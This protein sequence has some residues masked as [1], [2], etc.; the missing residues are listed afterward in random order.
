MN[1][2]LADYHWLTSD[3]AVSC[4]EFAASENN[5]SRVVQSLRKSLTAQRAHLVIEQ[6]ELRRRAKEKFASADQMFFTRQSLEQ[7]TD[8]RIAHD[9]AQRFADCQSVRA[10]AA[11]V[12]D[13]C[14]GIGGDLLAIA[15]R[16]L[17]TGVDLDPVISILAAANCRA[18]QIGDVRLLSQ[19]VRKTP[20]AE[21]AAWHLDPD[22]RA[23]GQRTT[24][25]E[26]Y[27][28]PQ[29]WID[30]ALSENPQAA[31][32]LAP[33]TQVPRHWSENAELCWYGSRRE[34]RQQVAWFGDLANQPGRR[35]VV[36]FSGQHETPHRFVSDS[37][38]DGAAFYDA[39]FSQPLG[40][41][42]FEPHAAVLAANLG[43]ALATYH[44]LRRICP[45]AAYFTGDAA[46]S[47]PLLDAFEVLEVL[48]LDRRV[49]NAALAARQI[50]EL[51]IKKR[52]VDIEPEKLRRELRLVGDQRATLLLV[53]TRP[54]QAVL[55]RRCDPPAAQDATAR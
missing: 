12:A 17:A 19:D 3:A 2:D 44:N 13:L 5:L 33:A 11:R 30:A 7:A 28:P 37:E 36:V 43:D 9:K 38:N 53:P 24:L 40:S 31:I 47:E 20:L 1:A 48:R 35:S 16:G 46:V 29:A 50:G 15:R 6:V 51:E 55:A 14:C 22:R 39:D 52:S 41:Y 10:P 27:E 34:C 18:L 23:T 8:E 25:L 32:K 42:I 4:L 21:F 45:E 54:V 49:I 26:Q